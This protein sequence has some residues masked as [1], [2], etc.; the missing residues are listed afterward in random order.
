MKDGKWTDWTEPLE[1]LISNVKAFLATVKSISS[2]TDMPIGGRLVVAPELYTRKER[3]GEALAAFIAWKE[4]GLANE[5]TFTAWTEN[6][7]VWTAEFLKDYV[8]LSSVYED[9]YGLA[10]DYICENEHMM[11]LHGDEFAQTKEELLEDFSLYVGNWLS[12]HIKDRHKAQ[13][14]Q[15]ALK[16]SMP[17]TSFVMI[18]WTLFVYTNPKGV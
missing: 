6:K 16:E 2:L 15:L 3:L 13:D 10:F 17:P 5:D 7:T 4:Y 9:A 11:E 8:Y 14:N 12:P 1:I 18:A